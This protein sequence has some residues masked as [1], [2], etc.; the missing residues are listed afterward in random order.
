MNNF[1]HIILENDF[2]GDFPAISI[3][4]TKYD[5]L[6]AVTGQFGHLDRN[7]RILPFSAASIRSVPTTST[8]VPRL[9]NSYRDRS[10]APLLVFINCL[11]SKHKSV[12]AAADTPGLL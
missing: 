9:K 8:R 1:I 6:Y 12:M 11:L 5:V 10:M 3:E 2:T 4:S 7:S